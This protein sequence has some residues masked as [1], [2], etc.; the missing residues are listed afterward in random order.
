MDT[1]TYVLGRGRA[2]TGMSV[3]PSVRSPL[4]VGM[5]LPAHAWSRAR[6]C[7]WLLTHS[8]AEHPWKATG[9]P[10]TLRAG[11]APC[12]ELSR[13]GD[14]GPW[15]VAW[16]RTRRNPISRDGEGSSPPAP[17]SSSCPSPGPPRWGC[18]SPRCAGPRVQAAATESGAEL[19]GEIKRLFLSQNRAQLHFPPGFPQKWRLA[20]PAT[21]APASWLLPAAPEL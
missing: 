4:L 9:P 8:A 21:C 11:R 14:K 6:L 3:C 15:R 18:C 12:E 17:R 10:G 7:P 5:G 2:W 20:G 16:P 1:A 13:A 19:R